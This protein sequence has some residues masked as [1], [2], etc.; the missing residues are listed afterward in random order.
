M[1]QLSP[2]GTGLFVYKKSLLFGKSFKGVF[3]KGRVV[4]G[5][6]EFIDPLS[7]LRINAKWKDSVGYGLVDYPSG[8]S[9]QG[10]F[11]SDTPN[12]YGLLLY[13]GEKLFKGY[14]KNGVPISGTG[15][16]IDQNESEF[17]GVLTNCKGV[18]RIFF[19]SGAV[20]QGDW[21]N[22][23][24]HGKGILKTGNRS[25]FTGKWNH[26]DIWEGEGEFECPFTLNFYSGKWRFGKGE[27][28][29]IYRD[30]TIFEGGFQSYNPII[31]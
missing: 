31:L 25:L 1:K 22:F 5:K 17:Q 29:L 30:G 18:G 14:F 6:G 8:I 12:G 24:M 23:K 3:N 2:H 13:P 19:A 26:G 21:I 28:K 20:Y 15:V 27:G 9:Y 7:G 10:H 11:T 4:S 16:F